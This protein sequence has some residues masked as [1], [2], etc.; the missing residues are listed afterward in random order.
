[1]DYALPTASDIP[2]MQDRPSAF[3]VAAQPARRQRRRRG[4]RGRAA[5]GDRQRGVRRVGAVW[6]RNQR[7]ADPADRDRRRCPWSFGEFCKMNS[8]LASFWLT[9]C[10]IAELDGHSAAGITHVLSILDPDWPDPPAF[11]AFAPHRRLA[12]RF[13]DIIEPAPD[14]HRPVPRGRRPAVDLWPRC[15]GVGGLP[16]LDPLPCRGVALDRR[17]SADP[18]A[19]SSRSASRRGARQGG[20]R[21]GR[22]HGPICG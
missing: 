21:C 19:G 14:R 1:M 5:G 15:R 13:H 10:G 8:D 11:A 2:A 18:G 9:I 6:A 20:A 7:D 12:L 17:G 22:A 16:S 4:R 3:A